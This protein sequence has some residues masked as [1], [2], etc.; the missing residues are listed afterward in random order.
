M[1][2]FAVFKDSEDFFV[3]GRAVAEDILSR[4]Y[5]LLPTSYYTYFDKL[6][7]SLNLLSFSLLILIITSL[8]LDRNIEI[9]FTVNNIYL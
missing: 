2:I 6:S 7:F 9:K 1:C 3:C 8:E 4:D 5:Y